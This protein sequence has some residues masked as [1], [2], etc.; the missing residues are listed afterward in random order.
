MTWWV[1]VFVIWA[2][3]ALLAAVFV[4]AAAA[5]S[6][7]ISQDEGVELPIETDDHPTPLRFPHDC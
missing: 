4:F 7:R 1:F 5:L 3:L 6:S 2:I